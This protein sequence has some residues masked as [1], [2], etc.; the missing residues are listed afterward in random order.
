M[1]CRD[2]YTASVRMIS[3]MPNSPDTEDYESRAPYLLGTVIAQLLPID[4]LYRRAIGDSSK[5]A[6]Q[7]VC[8]DLSSVFPLCDRF[9]TAATYYLAAM[10]V[11]EENEVLGDRLFAFYADE[12]AT[13]QSTLPARAEKIAD[14]YS[15]LI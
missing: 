4:K 1:L 10:L 3:E 2:V 13:I 7:S 5:A 11:M 15:A 9:V 6:T 12:V 14:R 8:V